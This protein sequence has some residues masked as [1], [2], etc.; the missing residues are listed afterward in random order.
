MKSQYKSKST[1]RR[2][3]AHLTAAERREK[4]STRNSTTSASEDE[5]DEDEDNHRGRNTKNGRGRA[6]KREEE[7]GVYCK[8]RRGYDGKEFMIGCDGCQEWFHGRCIGMT[9]SEA[10]LN[11]HYFCD[12][13]REGMKSDRSIGREKLKGKKIAAPKKKME[14]K[15]RSVKSVPPTV[16]IKKTKYPSSTSLLVN[17]VGAEEID[18]DICPVCEFECT[19]QNQQKQAPNSHE[20]PP[21]G[22]WS[23]QP[24]ATVLAG[25]QAMLDYLP[26]DGEDR[27][28]S[29]ASTITDIDEADRIPNRNHAKSK[30]R[31]RYVWVAADGDKLIVELKKGHDIV[32]L[33]G[34]LHF[35]S[36]NR[37]RGA[38]KGKG[39]SNVGRRRS[40]TVLSSGS[41]VSI[42]L[43]GETLSASEEDDV[44]DDVDMVLEEERYLIGQFEAEASSDNS[45][46]DDDDDEEE[47]EEE[48]EEDENWDEDEEEDDEEDAGKASDDEGARDY[49]L[50]RIE[51]EK[52]VIETQIEIGEE[53][54]E[55][56]DEG[57]RRLARWSDSDWGSEE[58]LEESW[59]VDTIESSRSDADTEYDRD[60]EDDEDGDE[61]EN[62]HGPEDGH[63]RDVEFAG[64]GASLLDLS[65]EA[66]VA[67]QAMPSEYGLDMDTS[68]DG[69]AQKDDRILRMFGEQFAA[70]GSTPTSPS[71]LPLSQP[72][73]VQD[74]MDARHARDLV[75][76]LVRA[77][78]SQVA[79]GS[80]GK[81]GR[82]VLASAGDSSLPVGSR[83]I[84][85][86][87]TPSSPEMNKA[88]IEGSSGAR[89][90][91]SEKKR[92]SVEYFMGGAKRKRSSLSLPAS[93]ASA[94]LGASYAA[95][96]AGSTEPNE[97]EPSP[98]PIDE[99]VDTE[100][101]DLTPS[102]SPSSEPTSPAN[103]RLL[104][105]L[106]RWERIPI[107]AFRRSRRLSSA[108]FIPITKALKS[109]AVNT[110]LLGSENYRRHPHH[111]Q[112][113]HIH[114]YHHYH[115][116]SS[117][118]F[119]YTNTTAT[120]TAS[121]QNTTKD[122]L[123]L[124]LADEVSK[125]PSS[126]CSTPLHSPLFSGM[127]VGRGCPPFSLDGDDL[128][129]DELALDPF[130]GLEE[131]NTGGGIRRRASV[132]GEKRKKGKKK[133][134]GRR[135]KGVMWNVGLN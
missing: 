104:K 122:D 70:L 94:E 12:K 112:H 11:Q 68:A 5:E 6:R 106:S 52:L 55:E 41:E 29:D 96:P 25:G 15:S 125:P 82:E 115:F 99:I 97:R 116:S 110:T 62:E 85:P 88:V 101:L 16:P 107:G 63:F 71:L 128:I 35:R 26:E 105:N 4:L 92:L 98:V 91:G 9:P 130:T 59:F 121:A 1:P 120:S 73:P 3:R 19:C 8:C 53:E 31:R 95:A 66:I 64:A 48:E 56:G 42:G 129:D 14:K 135:T 60:G 17:P 49:V 83:Q 131:V 61:S 36:T 58:E 69:P 81:R 43:E 27:V 72:T 32:V 7:D 22:K 47:D 54:E 134:L 79:A 103:Q 102:R 78:T 132:R 65:P 118:N 46:I 33:D 45:D 23:S 86:R 123:E 111:Y 21:M 38:G 44:G 40:A 51:S 127:I 124:V 30:G 90:A 50:T 114:H 39:K 117:R 76:A 57:Y 133:R 113:F 108:P 13:C 119:H 77:S 34:P 18:D 37:P 74:R 20:L 28:D 67:L 87:F 126:A 100:Q 89:V 75:S 24:S 2:K 84:L 80:S 10:K 109:S 93:F